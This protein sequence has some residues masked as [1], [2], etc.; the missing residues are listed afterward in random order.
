M[1]PKACKPARGG[2]FFRR[3]VAVCTG[4]AAFF[5]QRN[6]ARK[7]QPTKILCPKKIFHLMFTEIQF[8]LV[9]RPVW[10]YS[11]ALL[12]VHRSVDAHTE[13]QKQCCS[14]SGLPLG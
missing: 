14:H 10:N 9:C 6:D 11:F 4:I 5:R 12:S 2:D 3:E 7:I 13:Q 1:V 8:V